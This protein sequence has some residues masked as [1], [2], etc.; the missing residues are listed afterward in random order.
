MID[1]IGRA[2]GLASERIDVIAL[3]AKRAAA[4]AP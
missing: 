3:E 1:R 4:D 2:A